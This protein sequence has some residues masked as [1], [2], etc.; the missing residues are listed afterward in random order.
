MCADLAM[1]VLVPPLGQLAAVL[2]TGTALSALALTLGGSGMPLAA[3]SVGLAGLVVHVARGWQLS[4]TGVRGLAD[5]ARAPGYVAWKFAAKATR[6]FG[7]G[8]GAS[9]DPQAWV[10]TVRAAETATNASPVRLDATELNAR[11][12]V[13]T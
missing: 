4:D 1:D 3:W 5:L 10:R 8:S 11:G 12:A 7:G 9:P 2:L 6:S 13:T